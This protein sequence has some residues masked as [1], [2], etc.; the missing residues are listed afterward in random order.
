[1]TCNF[2][3]M[4]LHTICLYCCLQLRMMKVIC[5]TCTSL[6]MRDECQ[7][8]RHDF[9][10]LSRTRIL[11]R[12]PIAAKDDWEESSKFDGPQVRSMQIGGNVGIINYLSLPVG[13]AIA[14]LEALNCKYYNEHL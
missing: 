10:D 2:F 1:M 7:I 4:R 8:A 13:V 3:L 5:Q 11:P 9:S 12:L 14:N 6:W